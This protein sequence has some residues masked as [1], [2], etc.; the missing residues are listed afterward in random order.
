MLV[1]NTYKVSHLILSKIFSFFISPIFLFHNLFKKCYKLDEIEVKTILVTEYHRIGDLLLINDSL[2]SIKKKFP[3]AKLVLV[4]NELASDFAKEL[5]IAD[6]VLSI[7]VP[8]TNWDWSFSKWRYARTFA[9]KIKRKKI[10]LAFDFKGDIR[11]GWFLWHTDPK[12]SFGYSTTGG[13]YFF[14]NSFKMDYQKHQSLRAGELISKAGCYFFR[15][16]SNYTKLNKDGSIVFHTGS[17]DK[18]RSWP[19]KHWIELVKLINPNYKVTLVETPESNSLQNIL[20]R[21][22]YNIQTFKGN[23]IELKNWLKYQY[24]LI[25]VDSMAGHLAAYVGI[26]VFTIFGSNDPG[27][28]RPVSKVGEI[29]IPENNCNHKRIHWRF[30]EECLYSV[31]PEKVANCVFKKISELERQ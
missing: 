30:C 23:L 14:T 16:P 21:K 12:I 3:N 9:R 31:S 11:N 4:C 15:Q 25:G 2:I 7:N 10:D 19:I 29:I 6:E 17:S 5:K 20:K 26:P 8:W 24:C 27:L 1:N 22:N 18:K 28:T 13:N